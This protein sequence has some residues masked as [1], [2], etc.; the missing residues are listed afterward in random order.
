MRFSTRTQISLCQLLLLFSYGELALL[1]EKH[2][3]GTAE[4][5]P[6][7]IEEL[8]SVL[9]GA[10]PEQMASVLDEIIR[11]RWTLRSE[12]SPRYRFDERW[13]DLLRCLS[14]DGYRLDDRTLV[15]ADPAIEGAVAI[16][17]DLTRELRRSNLAEADD[18]IRT[19]MNS[20]DAFR[21]T[22]PDYNG[23]LSNARVALES[24]AR[25]I[26]KS[27]SRRYP[28]S[29]DETKWG[30]VLAYIRTSDFI[31]QREEA[32]LAGV[33]G[34]ISPRPYVPRFHRR[35]DGPARAKPGSA[36]V[37]FPGKA[38]QR[39]PGRL[40]RVGRPRLTTEVVR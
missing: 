32:G 3:L 18:I 5:T 22:P 26:A 25:A 37:L 24:L 27:R 13:D 10:T 39:W 8:R 19:L 12:V 20:A 11:T 14:L 31:S 40:S 15:A 6:T 9:S 36:N 33:Y 38:P 21:R 30:Q 2:G 28:G 35:R 4:W 29:F 17:D 16:E 23:C 1:F 34:L 7:T